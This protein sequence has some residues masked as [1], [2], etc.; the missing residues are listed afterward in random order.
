MATRATSAPRPAASSKPSYAALAFH[1]T[2]NYAF[3]GA[4]ALSTVALWDTLGVFP[5]AVGVGLEVL[6]M[7]VGSDLPFVKKRLDAKLAAQAAAEEA[8]RQRALLG[9]VTEADRRRY[10][11]M[12]RLQGEIEREVDANPSLPAASLAGELATLARLPS[13]FLTTA[14]EA[15]RLERFVARSDMNEL[16][17]QART[18]GLALEKLDDP[19]S[20]TLAQKNL[21]VLDKR[22]ER[23]KDVHKSLRVA[24]GQLNLIENTVRLVRDQIVTMQSPRELAGQLDELTGSIDAMASARREADAVMERIERELELSR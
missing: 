14:H 7:L 17:R 2:T 4:T 10:H 12:L 18:Q 23:A 13:Q 6:W 15:A 24:R 20:R 9:A 21:A 1:N 3:L 22:I 19:D 16:E 5:L 8:E 11:E